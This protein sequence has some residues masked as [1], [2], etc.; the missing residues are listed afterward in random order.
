MMN[1]KN[2]NPIASKYIYEAE[3]VSIDED[4]DGLIYARIPEIDTNVEDKDLAPC[5]PKFNYQFFRIKPQIGERVIISLERII[6]SDKRVNQE[7]RYWDALVISN[8]TNIA[9]DPFYF[10]SSSNQPNGW[11]ENQ[12]PL[13][14]IPNANGLTE[15]DNTL[16]IR[17]RNNTDLSL[18]NGEILL[19]SG[20]H[21]KNS[22]FFYNNIDPAYIQIKHKK[23]DVSEGEQQTII[24]QKNIPSKHII[25][26]S[27]NELKVLIK[28][29]DKD[30]NNIVDNYSQSFETE[31][32]L[33]QQTKNKII[34]FQNQYERWEFR[35]IDS[36]FDNLPTL[37]PNNVVFEEQTIRN[38]SDFNSVPA[39]INVVADHINLLSHKSNNFNI[40]NPNGQIDSNTQQKINKEAQRM[41]M[42]ENLIE[43][44]E[45]MR[46]FMTN[47]VHPYHG[48]APS[49][50]EL[51]KK[52]NSIDLEDLLNN[53]LRIN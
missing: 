46:Q 24:V 20:R 19:R 51:L 41:V 13:D 53:F 4:I 15:N 5:L 29:I 52:I 25:K 8:V 14:R 43:F 33:V 11:A 17:G 38:N 21:R 45:L 32:E 48:K 44:L 49:N 18:R 40:T 6:D 39:S 27:I 42:G 30:A 16:S 34:E 3:V 31:D 2:I 1:L 36:R 26:L 50:I 9:Y 10:T 22:S 7:K 47:H 23:E 35:S 37:F 12:I 28:V